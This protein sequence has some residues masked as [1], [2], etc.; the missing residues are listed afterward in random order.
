VASWLVEIPLG[1]VQNIVGLLPPQV[2]Q[3]LLDKVV[4]AFP[5]PSPDTATPPEEIG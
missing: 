5:P 3:E 4:A 1:K 2:I